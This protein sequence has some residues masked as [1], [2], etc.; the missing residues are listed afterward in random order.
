VSIKDR[1]RTILCCSMLEAAVLFGMP[2][3]AG[4]IEELMRSL[5]VPTL[6]HTIP[7]EHPDDRC[8]GG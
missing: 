1:L 3:R 2:M 5:N 6:A 7:D 8:P 4:Q